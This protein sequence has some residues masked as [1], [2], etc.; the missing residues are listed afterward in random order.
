[1]I[2]GICAVQP[3]IKGVSENIVVK[4]ILG[5]FL[6][7]SR[8]Y[9]FINGGDDEYWIGSADLMGRN[10]DRRVESLVMVQRKEHHVRLRSLLDL[11]LSEETSSWQLKETTWSRPNK[12]GLTNIHAELIEHYSKDR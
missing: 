2:R 5:R 7:H 8:I 11:G 9:H 12:K 4:S 6:E 3:G 10:L 1:L